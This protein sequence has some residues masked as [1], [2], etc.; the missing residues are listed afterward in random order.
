MIPMVLGYNQ[1]PN[2]TSRKQPQEY[3][4]ANLNT[5]LNNK[6]SLT[7]ANT[8]SRI[9]GDRQMLINLQKIQN[10]YMEQTTGT[11]GSHKNN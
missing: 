8:V 10:S 2:K 4:C 3:Y 6:M 5:Q 11:P 9:Y 1:K 7:N